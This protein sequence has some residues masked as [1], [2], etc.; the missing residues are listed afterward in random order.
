MNNRITLSQR[1][2]TNKKFAQ[3]FVA[4]D[5]SKVNAVINT[6][7]R[8]SCL[9]DR[10]YP[11]EV[12]DFNSPDIYIDYQ[13]PYRRYVLFRYKANVGPA[14]VLG[15]GE[16]PT[17][18]DTK[19]GFGHAYFYQ[20]K[21]FFVK[22]KQ[23][24]NLWDTTIL[25][26]VIEAV[27]ERIG[28]TKD[29]TFFTN[30][31]AKI[32]RDRNIDNVSSPAEVQFI[33]AQY[34]KT[35]KDIT[36]KVVIQDST[37]PQSVASGSDYF[38]GIKELIKVV[39]DKISELRIAPGLLL[40]PQRFWNGLS[41]W[42]F[43]GAGVVTFDIFV[44]T[45]EQVIGGQMMMGLTV[46]TTYKYVKVKSVSTGEV[47]SLININVLGEIYKNDYDT[48]G[49]GDIDE[50]AAMG[51]LLPSDE[52][53][54]INYA[55]GPT[56]EITTDIIEGDPRVRMYTEYWTALAIGLSRAYIGFPAR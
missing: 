1:D 14:V 8:E 25:D 36:G 29:T 52:M 18:V 17:A 4:G 43:G 11:P 49:T 24:I 13:N 30:G 51:Y 26:E 37:Q 54:A 32:V 45:A 33:N 6:V 35:I 20:I 53:F 34:F 47:N 7:I 48:S 22:S 12:R 15:V 31:I 28:D 10:I 46:Q 3:A 27:R 23:E 40:V 21:Y 2:Y 42:D 9:V 38:V 39:R 50:E 5:T 41:T 55:I 56:T 44:R 19:N 16:P